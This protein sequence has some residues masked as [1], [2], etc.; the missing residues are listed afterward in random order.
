[1]PQWAFHGFSTLE[2]QD[3]LWL[4]QHTGKK[5]DKTFDKQVQLDEEQK[6]MK[7]VFY[8]FLVI[9]ILAYMS[10]FVSQEFIDAQGIHCIHER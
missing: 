5:S 9:N 4:L 8:S 6:K 7:D 2:L 10:P 3:I 1:L